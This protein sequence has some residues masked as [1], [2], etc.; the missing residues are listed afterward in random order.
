MGNVI[1]HGLQLV[2][3]TPT[4]GIMCLADSMT[5]G[6]VSKTLF[7]V[8]RNINKSGKRVTDPKNLVESVK[9]PIFQFRHWLYSP[10]SM[11]V[12]STMCPV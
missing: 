6:C 8:L 3:T 11:A 12:F 5:A 2:S 4:V 9:V 7:S 1:K 10:H